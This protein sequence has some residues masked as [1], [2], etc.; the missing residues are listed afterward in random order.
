MTVA[1][2][3]VDAMA[4]RAALAEQWQTRDPKTPEEI[5]QFYRDVGSELEDDLTAFHQATE[6]KKWT[7]GLVHI[8][9]TF[10]ANHTIDVGCGAG[11]DLYALRALDIEHIVGI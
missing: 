5:L 8:A 1:T 11:H 2:P 7:E 10:K 3:P 4:A 9:K 6:R